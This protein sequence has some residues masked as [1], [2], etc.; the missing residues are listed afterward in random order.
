MTSKLCKLCGSEFTPRGHVGKDYVARF[1]SL[2]C[3]SK[4]RVRKPL[5]LR[6]RLF[7][8]TS[9]TPGCWLWVGFRNPLGYGHISINK[10]P[11]QAHRVMYELFKG[12]IPDGL[13]LDHLCRNPSCVNPDHLDPVTMRENTL[14]GIGPSAMNAV[15]MLC[16]RGHPFIVRKSGGRKCQECSNL[17]QRER[18]NMAA[19]AKAL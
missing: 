6:A 1:C 4:S 16:K 9:I 7:K 14:R 10:R 5:D 15:K 3:A 12:P 2:S 18:R 17:K 19:K 8:Y 13:T 11:H